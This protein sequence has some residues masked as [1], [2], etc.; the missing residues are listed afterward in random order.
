MLPAIV[1]VCAVM[2]LLPHAAQATHPHGVSPS[3]AAAGPTDLSAQ[4]DVREPAWEAFATACAAATLPR[5]HARPHALRYT[6]V[7][8]TPQYV[9]A[10]RGRV[11]VLVAHGRAHRVGNANIRFYVVRRTAAAVYLRRAHKPKPP[12][13]TPTPTPPAPLRCLT[14]ASP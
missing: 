1:L 14:V 9:V 13:P 6:I 2:A 5:A 12:T 4:K 3:E 11:R 10:K 7:K 8:R